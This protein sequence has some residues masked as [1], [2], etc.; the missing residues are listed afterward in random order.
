V[1]KDLA[2]SV[3]LRQTLGWWMILYALVGSQMA[4]LL[5]PFFNQTDV[6]IRPRSGNF[7]M[8]VLRVLGDFLSGG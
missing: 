5:R 3:P 7:F 2:Q 1:G 4:W 6:F 8:A